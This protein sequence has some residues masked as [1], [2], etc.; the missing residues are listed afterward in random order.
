MSQDPRL[1]ATARGTS[2][3]LDLLRYG[4][5]RTLQLPECAGSRIE[6]AHR[7]THA[8]HL[9]PYPRPPFSRV[10]GQDI[11]LQTV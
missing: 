1:S 2:E 3:N 7:P 6:F 4:I 5:T 10:R 11:P 8:I 9:S